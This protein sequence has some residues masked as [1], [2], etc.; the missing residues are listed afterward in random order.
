MAL[1]AVDTLLGPARPLDVAATQGALAAAQV[2]GRTERL[3]CP[4]RPDV[5]LDVAHNEDAARAL[6]AA[7]ADQCADVPLALVVAASPGRDLARFLRP[8]LPLAS[9][10]YLVASERRSEGAAAPDAPLIRVVSVTD[11]LAAAER[12]VGPDGR[13]LVTGTH[14]LVAA[15]RGELRPTWS[16]GAAAGWDD[17]RRYAAP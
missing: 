9:A 7:M 3:T 8:L 15:A 11:A 16:T 2:P 10:A 6:A 5:V 14:R 12:H 4:G 17:T 1:A 13:I